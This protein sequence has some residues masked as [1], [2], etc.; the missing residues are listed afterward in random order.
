MSQLTKK[1]RPPKK[2]DLPF[3]YN[4]WL[5]SYKESPDN[6]IK[7]DAYYSYHKMLLISILERS[8]ISI[9]CNPEVEDQIFGYA[10]YE[11]TEDSIVL[12]WLHVKHTYKRLGF[13]RFILDSIIDLGESKGIFNPIVTITAKG[14]SYMH[15]K[16]KFNHIYRPKLAFKLKEIV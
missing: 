12:H 6:P 15:I 1:L 11:L 5:E 4:S 10:I 13:A 2:T 14:L 7:G 9:L 8:I 16:D 3:I